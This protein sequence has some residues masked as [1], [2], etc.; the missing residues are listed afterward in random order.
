M[1]FSVTR[2][3][4]IF[5]TRLYQLSLL[6]FGELMKFGYLLKDGRDKVYAACKPRYNLTTK[7]CL[8]WVSLWWANYNL[9]IEL[10][11]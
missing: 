1:Q 9:F 2:S 3:K 5:V 8:S 7:Q 11:S 10:T 4:N 6:R